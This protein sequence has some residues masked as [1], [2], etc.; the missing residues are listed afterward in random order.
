MLIGVI[1][2]FVVGM[3]ANILYYEYRM[4]RR[5]NDQPKYITDAYVELL[6]IKRRKV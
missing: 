3:Y 6:R 4:P 2:L 1:G 5:I